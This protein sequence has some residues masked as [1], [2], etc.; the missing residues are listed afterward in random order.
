[1]V[2]QKLACPKCKATIRVPGA[3]Q[4][5]NDDDDWLKL[6]GDH[7]VAPP[8][9]VGPAKAT[10][11]APAAAA[12]TASKSTQANSN[13]AVA[14]PSSSK[15]TASDPAISPRSTANSK[16][17]D[18]H[19]PS[20][21]AA[22]P[23]TYAK[24]EDKQ[25]SH[26]APPSGEGAMRR[27]VFDDDLPDLL[28]LEVQPTKAPTLS[29]PS[30]ATGSPSKP[31]S[32]TGAPSS[33]RSAASERSN[34]PAS[35]PYLS[36]IQLE[37]LGA[38]PSGKAASSNGSKNIDDL[39]LN[40]PALGD[41]FAISEDDEFRFSC[42]VCGTLLNAS[43]TRI[44]KKTRCPDCY[45]ELT[46]PKPAVK[47]KPPE[48]KLDE[49]IHVKLAPIDTRDSRRENSSTRSTKEILDKAAVE[50]DREFEEIEA[51]NYAFD[52]KRWLSLIF[53][54]LR[55]PLVIMAAVIL[56]LV[57]SCWLFAI[58]AMGTLVRMGTAV[59]LFARVAI[60]GVFFFPIAGSIFLCGIAVLTMAANRAPKV[61][62]WPFSRLGESI[63]DCAMVMMSI[64]IASI[65]G[66]LLGAMI[67]SLGA[68]PVIAMGFAM[69]SIWGLSP[70]IL[71]S[72]INNNSMFEPYSNVVVQ[73]MKS[74][75]DAWG[76]MY[77]QSG[78]AYGVLFSFVA[79]ASMEGAWGEI[80]LGLVLPVI[81]MFIFNQIGVLAGRISPATE[82]GFQGDFSD[83]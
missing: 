64:F 45:S 22:G 44:G 25:A 27:S 63:G 80:A 49:K 1:L 15:A 10:P 75:G 13:P 59:A 39:S 60:L 35:D 6:D 36:D 69:V 19:A 2:G 55:D 37:A 23:I 62:D 43:K 12:S 65:P 61:E 46:I 76:A 33:A 79:I 77:I 20:Q 53:G 81:C 38:N 51:V 11:I 74:F 30:K 47:Q 82:L 50:A 58:E 4:S 52:T 18:S 41:D 26:V 28:A 71:L 24:T 3:V 29:N 66:G 57:T 72:M 48:I 32:P 56:G 40:S 68:N 42:K 67:M 17:V 21:A 14:N 5:R 31:S 34:K 8:A 16:A 7:V 78:L 70:I 54:F 83:D 73:S 9:Q